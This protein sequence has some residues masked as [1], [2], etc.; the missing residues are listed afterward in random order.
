MK[1]LAVFFQRALLWSVAALVSAGAA[2][3]TLRGLILTSPGVYHNY[4]LQTP[5]LAAGIAEHFDIHFDVSLA[6]TARW[7]NTDYGTGYDVLIYNLCMADE[8]DAA[9]IHNMRRQT[10]VLG[11]PAVVLHCSMHSFRN[12][13]LWWPMYGL[14][15]RAHEPETAL[16]QEPVGDHPILTGIP[17]N[18]TLAADEL[19]RNLAFKGQPLLTSQALDGSIQVTAWLYEEGGA[20]VFGTTLGHSD[21]SIADAAYQRLVANGILYVTGNLG[22]D[23]LPPVALAPVSSPDGVIDHLGAPEGVRFLGAEGQSCAYRRMAMAVAPCYLACSLHP[24]KWNAAADACRQDC[25]SRLP[26]NASL[27][28]ACMP[29]NG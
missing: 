5:T 11:V 22:P 12:T 25:Q 9:L 16:L 19:Y 28:T 17:T 1:A 13:D 27:I 8:T 23:G 18:W 26:G 21:S 24:F 15:T 3:E 2:A 29:D 20:R 10:D 4:A 6:E 7:K 14:Q